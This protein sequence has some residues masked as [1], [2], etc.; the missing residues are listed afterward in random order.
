MKHL[1]TMLLLLISISMVN[2]QT[3]TLKSNDI[4]GQAKMKQVFNSFGCKGENTSL[5]L[6]WVNSPAG[7]KSFAITMYDPNALSGSGWWQWVVF[8]IPA[9]TTSLVENAGN[10][11]LKLAPKVRYKV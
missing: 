10:A 1:L 4:E 8:N 9:N 5:E 3:F 7:T 2:A 6:A 11:M